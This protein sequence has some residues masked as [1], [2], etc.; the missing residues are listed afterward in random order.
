MHLESDVG[1]L[2]EGF[3]VDMDG[4]V[5]GVVDGDA[6]SVGGAGAVGRGVDA[7]GLAVFE[8]DGGLGKE[9]RAEGVLGLAGADGIE[10]ER[11]EDVPGRHGA[12]VLVAAE[13]VGRVRLV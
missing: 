13:V 2:G 6:G 12:G 11:T 5:E 4:G 8:T 3:V 1:S 7:Q 10:A 9:R